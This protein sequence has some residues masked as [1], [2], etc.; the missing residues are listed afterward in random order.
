MSTIINIIIII[1][2]YQID[3]I[4]LILDNDDNLVSYKTQVVI[5]VVDQGLVCA[6]VF[7]VRVS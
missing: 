6:R 2:I 5:F 7:E 3:S 1:N 4:L